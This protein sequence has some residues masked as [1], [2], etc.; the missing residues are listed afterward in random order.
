MKFRIS[1]DTKGTAFSGCDFVV[2]LPKERAGCDVRIL[3]LTDMQI[4]DSLQRRT[5]DRIRED[6]IAAWLPEN[7]DS[8]C[9]NHIRS[10]VA[11]S[12]PDLIII[13]GDIV[14][15]SFDDAGSGMKYM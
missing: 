2:E 4:I 13:T 9:G 12:R 10:L 14:Y 15:G 8:L 3:Q 11:Q 5:P 7:Y 1:K 6:E